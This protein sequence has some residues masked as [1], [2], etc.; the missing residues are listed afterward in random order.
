M[1]SCVWSMIYCFVCFNCSLFTE[2]PSH[3]TRGPTTNVKAEPEPSSSAKGTRGKEGDEK[4]KQGDTN[5]DKQV[6]GYK[7]D[8]DPITDSDLEAQVDMDDPVNL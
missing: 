5:T 8:Q 6:N 1:V 7:E 4:D 3:K 2:N